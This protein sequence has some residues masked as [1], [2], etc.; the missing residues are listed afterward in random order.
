MVSQLP[1][2]L[3]ERVIQYLKTDQFVKAKLIH[4]AWMLEADL[5]QHRER[6]RSPS[7]P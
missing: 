1:P 3:Q 5:I 6:Q 7:S 4:D 2:S